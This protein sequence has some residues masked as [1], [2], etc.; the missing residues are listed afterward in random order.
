MF[1]TTGKSG[2]RKSGGGGGVARVSAKR[3]TH[4]TTHPGPGVVAFQPD[5]QQGHGFDAKSSR[6]SGLEK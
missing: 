5:S 1:K 6:L 3:M 4:V 2:M